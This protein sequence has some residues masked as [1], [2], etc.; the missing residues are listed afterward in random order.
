MVGFLT[1]VK[2]TL[3]KYKFNT[4]TIIIVGGNLTYTNFEQ[5]KHTKAILG[6]RSL[7]NAGPEC[8][9]VQA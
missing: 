2:H 5:T 8:I 9:L 6:I 7:Y 4:C 3:R 1:A